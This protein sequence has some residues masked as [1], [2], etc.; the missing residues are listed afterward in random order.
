MFYGPRKALCSGLATALTL[1]AT[2]A[3]GA[4]AQPLDLGTSHA[5]DA[6]AS[7]RVVRDMRSPDARETA[8]RR[9]IVQAGPP[10]W[11]LN[12]QPL[13]RRHAVVEEPTSGLDWASAG[14]G[15]ATAAGTFAIAVAGIVGLRRRRIAGLEP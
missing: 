1:G 12:P 2:A 6:S 5:R 13:T 15:V 8:E 11:P 14:I 7:A 3:P 9:P 4:L 10:T